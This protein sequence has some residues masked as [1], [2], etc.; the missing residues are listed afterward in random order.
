MPDRTLFEPQCIGTSLEPMEQTG[1]WHQYL[2]T[3]ARPEIA[4][5]RR[6]WEHAFAAYPSEAKPSFID[7]FRGDEFHEALFE[8]YVFALMRAEGYR[9][10]ILATTTHQSTPDF[11][12][13]GVSGER[14]YVEAF[15]VDCDPALSRMDDALAPLKVALDS[16]QLPHRFSVKVCRTSSSPLPYGRMTRAIAAWLTSEQMVQLAAQAAASGE[17]CVSRTFGDAGWEVE[18]EAHVAGPFSSPVR[19]GASG[20]AL[21]GTGAR[22]IEPTRPLAK[23]L[24]N[25]A[26]R[27]DV[28]GS[29][30]LAVSPMHLG[31]EPD[32]IEP[33]LYGPTVTSE[34]WDGT[35]TMRREGGGL[36]LNK[37][38]T[39]RNRDI[40]AVIVC[41][42]VFPAS[43]GTV[44]P[45]CYQCPEPRQPINEFLPRVGL[46]TFDGLHVRY[47]K[48][49]TGRQ[50]FGLHEEWPR[51][52][53]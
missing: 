11:M 14:I 48:G 46:V 41:P 8:L 12:V 2:S 23:R 5:V 31:I 9:P 26:E 25:K 20:V 30:V 1:N 33:A 36:W 50:Y 4:A 39:S 51:E 18:I 10:H 43:I 7:R 22:F 38:K 52:Q 17:L 6:F 19:Q 40:P 45:V 28:D 27:Y 32:D 24:K 42:N 35:A 44:T 21:W 47:R 49:L 15:I 16:V 37:D 53:R 3:S 34:A 13:T 29:L